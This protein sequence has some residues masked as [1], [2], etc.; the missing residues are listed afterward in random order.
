MSRMAAKTTPVSAGPSAAR[1]ARVSKPPPAP[2]ERG[3]AATIVALCASVLSNPGWAISAAAHIVLLSALSVVVFHGE[4]RTGSYGLEGDLA[5]AVPAEAFE[6]LDD[7]LSLPFQIADSSSPGQ[8]AEQLRAAADEAAARAL[9]DLDR[10]GL[11]GGA[12]GEGDSGATGPGL[13][14]GF[15]GS[16]GEGRSFV[17]VVDMSQSMSGGRF[18]RAVAELTRSINRLKP[19]QSFYV[20]FF[21]DETYPLYHPRPAKGLQTATAANKAKAG[22]WIN[23]RRPFSTTDPDLALQQAL[24]MKPDVIFLLTDGELDEPD[25]VRRSIRE[26]NTSSVTIHTI[27]FEN[28]EASGTLKQIA[29]ENHGTF[30]FVK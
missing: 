21:N 3:F 11:A 17:Y 12:A 19:A 10:L 13:E 27:A 4:E 1:P 2:V 5:E 30:Q 14:A 16:K 25:R 20:L 23:S 8:R 9:G 26:H 6:T 7:T 28:F 29:D 22:R 15:F 24:E 18:R